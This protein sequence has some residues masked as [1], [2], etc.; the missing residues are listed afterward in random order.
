MEEILK[1][2]NEGLAADNVLYVNPADV[3]SVQ[4]QREISGGSIGI[5]LTGGTDYETKEITVITH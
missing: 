3:I 1:E 4:L 2:V 5:T